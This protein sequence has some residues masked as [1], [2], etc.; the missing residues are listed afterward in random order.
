MPTV[1]VADRSGRI[2][3]RWAGYEEGIEEDLS[4]LIRELLAEEH[5][6][7]IELGEVLRGADRLEASW[8]RQARSQI[9]GVAVL[10]A[11]KPPDPLLVTR[12]RS[13]DIFAGDGRTLIVA[14]DHLSRLGRGVRI[15]Q[16]GRILREVGAAGADAVLLRPGIVARHAADIGRM[17][18]ILSI[19]SD[20]K[21]GD[22]GVEL[23]LR[24]GADAVKVE[25]FPGS[26]QAPDPRAVLGPLSERCA[27]WSLPLLA[28]TIPVSFEARDAHTPEHLTDAA[29]LAADLGVDIVKTRF[30]GDADSF[31]GLVALAGLPVVVLGGSKGDV[32]SLFTAVRQSLDFTTRKALYTVLTG[33]LVFSMALICNCTAA[34]FRTPSTAACLTFSVASPRLR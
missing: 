30:T 12:L 27:A 29:R 23:A 25:V 21:V 14:M 1:I 15:H 5:E 2:R 3:A 13:L 31:A 18:L 10:S 24:L 26:E 4:R 11:K 28:E 33:A 20:R 16:P 9:D 17:G 34:P 7:G 32:E 6:P 22:W 8:T 19:G